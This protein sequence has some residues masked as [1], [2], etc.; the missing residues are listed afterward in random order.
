M[1]LWTLL[2]AL[3]VAAITALVLGDSG[4]LGGLDG[5]MIASVTAMLAL[6]IFLGS[7][8]A[9]DY[10]GRFGKA[11]KDFAIWIT[12]ALLLII[13]YSFR[14][15]LSVVY[16]RVAGELLP[17]GTGLSVATQEPGQR[18]VRIRQ[19]PDG[20][21]VVRSRV[22]GQTVTM[23]VDTGAS[24]IVLTPADA[25]AAGIATEALN[26]SVP[27][28]TANG[29]AFAAPVRIERISI[30]PIE[31]RN[32]DALVARPGALGESLLGM[33][34]LRELGDFQFTGEFLT[35]RG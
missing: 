27:V 9:T 14:D 29:M 21:F 1:L 22:N 25:A 26:Y 4:T 6:L 17:P 23:L 11:L 10:A 15:E 20:H 5:G 34:F 2:I 13:G 30:G 12:M 3:L 28:S 8:L 19:R 33:N 18:A 16:Q 24:T 7:D 31:M 35:L 32:M